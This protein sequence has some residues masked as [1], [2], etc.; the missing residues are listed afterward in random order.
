MQITLRAVI[1]LFAM[2]GIVVTVVVATVVMA[3][4]TAIVVTAIVV[5][6][7]V[8]MAV[9]VTTVMVATIVLTTIVITTINVSAVVPVMAIVSIALPIPLVVTARVGIRDRARQGSE[10]DQGSEDAFHRSLLER[11]D[12]RRPLGALSRNSADPRLNGGGQ[13]AFRMAATLARAGAS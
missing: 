3:I 6:A 5:T 13:V 9:V 2:A 10:S 8:V 12:L 7:I 4:V 1:A 11:V